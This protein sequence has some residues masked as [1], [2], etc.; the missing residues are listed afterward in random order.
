MGIQV[1]TTLKPFHYSMATSVRDLTNTRV[2]KEHK[3]REM[4][5]GNGREEEKKRMEG[6]N[7]PNYGAV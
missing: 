7:A 5:R 6:R 4:I 3:D 2:V 1:C